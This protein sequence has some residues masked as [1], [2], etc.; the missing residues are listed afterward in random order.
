[1]RKFGFIKLFERIEKLAGVR[2]S[3]NAKEELKKD[4]NRFVFVSPDIQKLGTYIASLVSFLYHRR[5]FPSKQKIY[6]NTERNV[7]E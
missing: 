4:P 1:M 2:I 6:V 3:H 5:S 7:I